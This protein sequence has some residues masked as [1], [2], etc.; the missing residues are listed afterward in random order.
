ML[1]DWR[2]PGLIPSAQLLARRDPGQRAERRRRRRQI[3]KRIRRV[4]L[5]SASLSLAT[6]VVGHLIWFRYGWTDL[7]LRCVDQDWEEW[8]EVRGDLTPQAAISFERALIA[9]YG[10]EAVQRPE[11][12]HVVVRPVVV[13]FGDENRLRDLTFMMTDLLTNPRDFAYADFEWSKDC[14][15]V[16]QA[17]MARGRAESCDS[18]WQSW[19]L[20]GLVGQ[21]DTPWL[22]RLFRVDPPEE[23]QIDNLASDA[24]PKRVHW[25]SDIDDSDL[26]SGVQ[27]GPSIDHKVTFTTII[28]AGTVI[29][30][31]KSL[32][33]F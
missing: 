13:V 29:A 23:G 10:E 11:P 21:A 31:V 22:T 2:Q 14:R 1:D 30:A 3:C 17:L 24:L 9:L 27:C 28:F 12:G 19:L 20:R 7:P 8:R 16:Q 25:T 33:P 32:W 4:L 15:V 18:L 26:P 5:I 6:V